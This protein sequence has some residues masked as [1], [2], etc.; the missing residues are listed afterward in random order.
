[1]NS[2]KIL[3]KAGWRALVLR[4]CTPEGANSDF[5]KRLG[6]AWKAN[7]NV[8][9]KFSLED[10][11]SRTLVAWIQ[12]EQRDLEGEWTVVCQ[13]ES[14]KKAANGKTII[15]GRC[16]II[17]CVRYHQIVYECKRLNIF[18]TSGSIK[19]N[20]TEYITE[21][22]FRFT[23]DNKYKSNDGFCGMIAY[24]MDGNL[25]IALNT[26]M[27][28]L[29]EISPAQSITS[30]TLP[31]PCQESYRLTTKH[32]DSKSSLISIHHLLFPVI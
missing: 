17:L 9:S 18:T 20:A 32:F 15:A 22:V 19:S 10:E 14:L 23:A 2:L 4:E 1:M 29:S 25:K 3:G 6:E 26:I 16:D 27:T 24:V 12:Q 21:G 11:I 7:Q 5:I 8:F 31:F 28:R 30:P 13:A